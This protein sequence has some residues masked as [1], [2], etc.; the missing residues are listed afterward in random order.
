M[1]VLMINVVCGLR[2]TGRICTDLAAELE[3]RGHEV[4]IA[5]GR[6]EVPEQFRKYAVRTG[7]DT[8]VRLH[9]LKA[10]LSDGAGFGSVSATKRFIGWVREYD[11]DVIHLHNIHGYY[12]NAEVLFDYLKACGKRIVWTL[13]D[14]W[15]FTGHAAF[16][17]AAGCEKW[18]DGCGD[19]PKRMDY[20]KSLTDNSAFNWRR[21]KDLFTS[22][23]D[24]AIVTPSEWLAGLVK[25][26]FLSGYPVTV[27]RN[28]ID[29]QV[30]RPVRGKMRERKN[31]RDKTVVLGVASVWDERKGLHDFIRL[32]DLLDRSRYA[33]VLVGLSERQKKELPEGMT[34]FT[35]TDSVRQ[36]VEL[37]STADVYVNPTYEDNYPTTNLEAIACGTPVIT[38][39][40]GGSPESARMFGKIIPKGNVEEIAEAIRTIDSIRTGRVD[41]DYRSA[42][43]KYLAVYLK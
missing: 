43:P 32:Y 23:P 24:M 11:P 29:T 34:G 35:R 41:V 31:I 20:P 3:A 28:G 38:Y 7:S 39:N 30:F 1:K 27:I 5:Y 13:H 6:E 4:K 18:R 12:L 26:S 2:S 17:E 21:K 37:Y 25:Q 42:L 36:L 15:A 9:A 19:C 22:V 16:C 8:D 10:R 33:I 14:C 40:T